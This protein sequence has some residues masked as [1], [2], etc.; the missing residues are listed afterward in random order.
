MRTATHLLQRVTSIALLGLVAGGPIVLITQSAHASNDPNQQPLY[1]TAR[2]NAGTPNSDFVKKD[3]SGTVI[4]YGNSAITYQAPS[5][6][7]TQLGQALYQQNCASCHGNQA[8]GVP[9]NGTSGA[10]PNLVGLGPATI[11]FWIESGRMPAAD[12]RSVQAARRY[13]RLTHDQALAIAAWV[14]SLYPQA[15]PYIPT[16][17]LK[18]ANVADGA[19][20]FALN[21]A[22]CHTIEGDGD[23][24]AQS[25]FA[26]SLRHIPATQV[27]EAIRTGPGNM[28][29]FTGN[30]SDYQVND[31]VK[32]VTTEIQHPNN[33]GGFGLGGLGPVAEGFVG[34]A[35][36]VGLL[37]LVGYWVGER[38]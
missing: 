35:L 31:I 16:P 37:A 33:P 36:G 6:A 1:Q 12:P 30:L 13:P 9:A 20:L 2:K 27:A 17:H 15:Y 32:Y 19:A 14:T 28:P 25:T 24:L 7:L 26:P 8:N 22:A 11:D 34:L 23:A 29:R 38:Q 3:A 10:Y 21:C 4:A 18:S 5:P